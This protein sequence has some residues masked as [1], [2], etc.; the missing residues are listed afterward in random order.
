MTFTKKINYNILYINIIIIILYY[1][2]KKLFNY[3]LIL[4]N[5]V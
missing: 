3:K 4:K 5:I 2:D 1:Q